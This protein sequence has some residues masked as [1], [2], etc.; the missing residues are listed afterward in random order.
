M[1][2]SLRCALPCLLLGV[3]LLGF[4]PTAHAQT[5]IQVDVGRGPVTVYVPSS[6]DPAERTPLLILLHAILFNGNIQEAYFKLRP[7]AE[8]RGILYAYPDGTV[9]PT[10]TR[11]W[12]AT[13]ACCDFYGSGVDDEGYVRDLLDAIERALN[14]D[15]RRVWLA[16]HS[17]GGFLGHRLIC[18]FG[19][20][21]A[22]LG[23]LAGPT[24]KDPANCPATDPISVLQ[25]HGTIDPVVL[26]GGGF[27]IGMPPYP[28]VQYTA[29]WW[30]T[31]NG[32]DPVDKS[33][34]WIDLSSL[35]VGK[36]T[37]VWRW[38]NGRAGTEVEHWKMN[39]SQHSPVF[40]STFA[41]RFMDWFEAHPR[42]GVGSGF[43][44][45]HVNSSGRPARMDAEGSAS[46]AAADLTLRAVALPPGAVGG[47]L[48]GEERD[49]T[50]FGQGVR[51]VA[52]GNL[53]RLLLA[54]ADGTGTARYALTVGAPGFLAGTT[55]HFQ[56]LFRDG[57]GSGPGM[58]DGLSITFLP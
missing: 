25:V 41:P 39:L 27:W 20:R 8:A 55:H 29:N 7:E 45:S 15:P 38:K 47:F 37:Q 53:R 26:Y 30:G 28:G 11:F 14:V 18:S 34:P 43:C 46:V 24:W 42:A 52:G 58:T 2:P 50:P 6:Y 22:A 36:E 5:T 13:D 44:E 19:E 3:G 10:G 1:Q 57:S 4:C 16:G 31:F 49:A 40:N 12:N 54:Q 9:D 51:C 33:A 35:V 48:H 32:C 17:N 21:F 23:N 56:F